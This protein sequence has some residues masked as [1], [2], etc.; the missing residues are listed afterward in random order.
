MTT[1]RLKAQQGCSSKNY[2]TIL[3]MKQTTVGHNGDVVIY[4]YILFAKKKD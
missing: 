4:Y 1:N 2:S 3:S